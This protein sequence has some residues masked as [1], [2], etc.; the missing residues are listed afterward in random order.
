MPLVTGHQ[1]GNA[2]VRERLSTWHS[3]SRQVRPPLQG[4]EARRGLPQIAAGVPRRTDISQEMQGEQGY[5]FN[6]VKA[7]GT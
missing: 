6:T 5:P 1:N 2:E 7:A 3:G 4:Q